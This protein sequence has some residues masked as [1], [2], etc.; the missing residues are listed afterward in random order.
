MWGFL[1]AYFLAVIVFNELLE[2][3]EDMEEEVSP[4]LVA[5]Q[6]P[7]IALVIIYHKLFNIS[8]PDDDKDE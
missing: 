2:A 5:L 7:W 3:A 1:V 6:F 8:L 4:V